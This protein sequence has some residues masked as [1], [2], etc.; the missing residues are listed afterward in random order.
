MTFTLQLTPNRDGV[1]ESVKWDYV[2][3]SS[4]NT[5]NSNLLSLCSYHNSLV[6]IISSIKSIS[7]A[8]TLQENC[9]HCGTGLEQLHVLQ[10]VVKIILLC[11]P[12][13]ACL[14][15]ISFE[16][17]IEHLEET[18]RNQTHE[19]AY[20]TPLPSLH[21]KNEVVNITTYQ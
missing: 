3:S 4:F 14:I 2:T 20:S 11:S 18:C 17:K 1:Q 5:R 12:L 8:V 13:L 7:E 21:C 6:I 9:N 16:E 15:W 10:N 19:K